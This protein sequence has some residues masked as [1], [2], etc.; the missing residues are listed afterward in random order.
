MLECLKGK[1]GGSPSKSS[2]NIFIFS[3]YVECGT[4]VGLVEEVGKNVSG[5]IRRFLTLGN[6]SSGFQK[7]YDISSIR[8]KTQKGR[9]RTYR[10]TCCD[11]MKLSPSHVVVGR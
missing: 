2:D 5:I 7:L 11:I 1:E 9:T 6:R 3:K 10:A 4:S 8:L